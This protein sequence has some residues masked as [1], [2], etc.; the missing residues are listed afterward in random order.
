[1]VFD[2]IVFGLTIYKALVQ[3][4]LGGSGSSLLTLKLQDGDHFHCDAVFACLP[5]CV[6]QV[7]YTLGRPT[8]KEKHESTFVYEAYIRVMATLNIVNILTF[9]VCALLSVDVFESSE[10]NT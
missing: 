10:H 6:L 4:R 9:V 2:A 5:F 1:M 7:Q 8:K 3:H